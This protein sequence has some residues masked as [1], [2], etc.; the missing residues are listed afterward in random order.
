MLFNKNKK[1]DD[2]NK[3]IDIDK[4][5]FWLLVKGAYKAILPFVFIIVLI[6]FLFTLFLTKVILK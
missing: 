1:K 6:Y 5:D 3:K 4:Q 2:I